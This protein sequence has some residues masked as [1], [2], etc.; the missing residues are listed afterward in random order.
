M[1]K[2]FVPVLAVSFTFALVA[3]AQMRPPTSPAG[4]NAALTKLFGEI[5][6]FSA[7]A[8]VQVLGKDQKEK[9]STPMNFALLDNKMRVEI[10]MTQMKN[11]DVPAAAAASMKQLGM[12]R[13]ISITRP[14]K[15]ATHI[16]FPGLQSYVN[17]PLS[18]EDAEMFEKDPKIEKTALGKETIDGHPCV[19]N[20]IVI[21][22]ANGQKDEAILWNATDLK[23]FPV[24]IQT[25]EKDDIVM[26]RYKD[27]KLIR[28][29]AKEFETPASFKEYG[30]VQALMQGVMM[31]MI[32]NGGAPAQ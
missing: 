28:P 4:I 27:V 25:K 16:I 2:I 31:K 19:K 5:T 13:I 1:K 32:G 23:G 22:D 7:K 18:K 10:D 15:K 3:S 17:L 30:D 12:D 14:D 20:K 26:L 8:D 29:D 9:V 21:T 24:Q 6:A 11:K